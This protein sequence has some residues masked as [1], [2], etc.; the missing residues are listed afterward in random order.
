[1][2]IKHIASFF[3]IL[4]ALFAASAVVLRVAKTEMGWSPFGE[5]R[6]SVDKTSHAQCG[7]YIGPDHLSV[8]LGPLHLGFPPSPEAQQIANRN[9][10][11]VDARVIRKHYY[12]GQHTKEGKLVF[13]V[14]E[15]HCADVPEVLETDYG[16]MVINRGYD[17]LYRF[18]EQKTGRIRDFYSLEEAL[19]MVRQ[20][21]PRSTF[22]HYDKCTVSTTSGAEEHVKLL[23]HTAKKHGLRVR[24]EPFYV[25]TCAGVEGCRESPLAL[26]LP[27]RHR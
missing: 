19:A 27:G 6:I 3:G 1:M 4:C 22:A 17:T 11:K 13:H 7:P 16:M 23:I 15:E 20:L 5:W 2:K 18:G 10:V 24:P 25:C 12:L 9:A 14:F 26:V 21:P 8:S